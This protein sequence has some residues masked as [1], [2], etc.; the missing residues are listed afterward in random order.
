VIVESVVAFEVA[1]ALI[2]KFGG[3][4]VDEMLA[5]YDL[6]LKMARAQ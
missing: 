2:D 3:D 1:A 4:S 6:F 5:R